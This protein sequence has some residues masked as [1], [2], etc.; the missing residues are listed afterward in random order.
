MLH[1]FQ[2]NL[3]QD[4]L[5][6]PTFFPTSI[7]SKH[8]VKSHYSVTRQFYTITFQVELTFWI[9]YFKHKAV[10]VSFTVTIELLTIEES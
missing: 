4:R 6:M 2:Y 8:N 9:P 1:D 5:E 7:L 10:E 3:S